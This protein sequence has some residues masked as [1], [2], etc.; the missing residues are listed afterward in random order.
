M[1]LGF[2]GYSDFEVSLR[3]RPDPKV[4]ATAAHLVL[5]LVILHDLLE[6]SIEDGNGLRISQLL[7]VVGKLSE[8]DHK[9]FCSFL[10]LLLEGVAHRGTPD[11]FGMPVVKAPVNLQELLLVILVQVLD[12]WHG[13][14]P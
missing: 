2:H 12:E 11:Q 3:R 4:I 1:E 5:Y 10:D 14:V 6:T 13:K 8:S 7:W 9:L